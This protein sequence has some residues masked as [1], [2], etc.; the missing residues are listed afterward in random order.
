MLAGAD[1]PQRNMPHL[2]VAD[3]RSTARKWRVSWLSTPAGP[4]LTRGVT[5]GVTNTPSKPRH[6]L[7]ASLGLLR[8]NFATGRRRM[9]EAEGE[10]EVDFGPLEVCL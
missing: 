2:L 3:K 6:T 8:C 9:S 5:V 10:A 7:L 1:L 4:H